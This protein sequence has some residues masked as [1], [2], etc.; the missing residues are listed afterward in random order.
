[1]NECPQGPWMASLPIWG[2]AREGAVCG[3]GAGVNAARTRAN[4]GYTAHMGASQN[5]NLGEVQVLCQRGAVLN[6]TKITNGPRSNPIAQ[7]SFPACYR[8]RYWGRLNNGQGETP[9]TPLAR[10]FTTPRI[11]T[12]TLPRP[13]TPLSSTF[14][15]PPACAPPLP[16]H[17]SC[18]PLLGEQCTPV[19]P[20]SRHSL[21][22]LPPL[23]AH[24]PTCHCAT[25]Q[26][27]PNFCHQ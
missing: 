6:I 26:Q 2:P 10:V 11:H 5:G 24:L 19:S 4:D 22:T 20:L 21:L 27:L 8:L 9:W 25:H 17:P 16:T 13:C 23:A 12:P 14:P 1:M 7:A 18:S 15:T 3:R